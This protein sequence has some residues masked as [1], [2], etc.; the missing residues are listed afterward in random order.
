MLPYLFIFFAATCKAI[1]DTLQ[2]HFDTSI[3]S[4]LNPKFWDPKVSCNHVKLL[5]FTKYRPDAWHLLNSGM[6]VLFCVACSVPQGITPWYW[7]ICFAGAVFNIPFNT[8]Y[9]LIL[10]RKS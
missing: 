10:K 6:I 5:R 4:K 8:I 7:K 3:F 2:H 1:A 9:N